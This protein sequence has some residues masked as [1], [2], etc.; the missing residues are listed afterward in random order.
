VGWSKV[1][2]LGTVTFG[3]TAAASTR[4]SFSRPGTHVPKLSA[5]D[6]ARSAPATVT[7]RVGK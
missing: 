5:T 2:G 6:G 7:I 1:K 4:A 3:N